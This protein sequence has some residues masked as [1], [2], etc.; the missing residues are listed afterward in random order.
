MPPPRSSLDPDGYYALLDLTP[1]ASRDAIIAAYRAQARRLH[2]DVPGTGSVTAFLALKQAYDVLSNQVQR[3]GYDREARAAAMAAI[4]PEVFPARP[5]RFVTPAS[6][7]PLV[8]PPR[9]SDMPVAVW[10]GSGLFLTFCIVQ[11]IIHLNAVPKFQGTDIPPTAQPVAP[12]TQMA[13]REVLYGPIPAHL[14]GTAN[15]YVKPSGGTATLYHLQPD[16]RTLTPA[17]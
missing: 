10:I 12:L 3:S 6:V 7:L 16:H 4:E 17:G 13:H 2:P 15:F 1:D 5:V 9:L 8:R 11:V 14:P